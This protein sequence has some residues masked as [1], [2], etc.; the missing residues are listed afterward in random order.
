MG[1]DVKDSS[2]VCREPPGPKKDLNQLLRPRKIFM[3]V[4]LSLVLTTTGLV[5]YQILTTPP[6]PP[7]FRLPPAPQQLTPHGA[8]WIDG[9]A[10]FSETALLEGWPGDGSA[11]NPYIIESL[12]IDLE[13]VG[14]LGSWVN[15]ISI[16][17][18]R[19]NFTIRNCNL[20]NVGGFC[21]SPSGIASGAGINLRNASNGKLV[22][23]TCN[24]NTFGIYLYES[25]SSTVV[26][27]TCT[28]S[29]E[30]IWIDSSAYCTVANNT[31][32]NNSWN[33]IFLWGSIS[34]TI[35]NNTC[36]NNRIGIYLKDSYSTIV[37]NNICN[38]ND[39]G[40]YLL[41]CSPDDSNWNTVA[42]NTCNYNMIGIKLDDESNYNIVVNNN[43]LGNIMRDIVGEYITEEDGTEEFDPVVLMFV[44]LG[45]GVMIVGMIIL[46][47]KLKK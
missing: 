21:E 36:N 4:S 33:G 45:A 18:T 28:S 27:N 46:V 19:V 31:C 39:Y 5:Y 14:D 23:N 11:G 26:N 32:N 29:W 41:S 8:I 34:N 25:D 42:N 44:T 6:S 2:R 13:G 17:N 12:D 47:I 15:C 10:N 1:Q 35:T 24:N 43:F 40:I 30:G 9:D 3:A 20:T 37:T 7:P 22:N 38:N 16:V